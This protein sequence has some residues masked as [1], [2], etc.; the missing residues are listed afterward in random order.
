MEMI[1]RHGYIFIHVRKFKVGWMEFTHFKLSYV[2]KNILFFFF[3][4]K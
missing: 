4:L 1:L 2:D 3:I